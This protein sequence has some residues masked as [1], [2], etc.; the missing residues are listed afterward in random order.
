ML[1]LPRS[2]YDW[3]LRHL[4]T[5]GDTDLFPAQFEIAAIK[6]M[7]ASLRAQ[8]ADMDLSSY[9]WR[10][11]R[12]FVV[13]KSIL[14]FRIAT[15]LDPLDSLMFA[16]LIWKFGPAL[17]ASRVPVAENRVFSFRLAP[18]ENG[19]LYAGTPTW[20]DFWKTSL[21]KAESRST[22]YVIIADI[23]DFYNQVYHHVLERQLTAA[24]LPHDVSKVIKK[25]VQTLTDK[26]SRGVPVGPHTSHILGECALDAMDRSLL[27]HG[28][29]FC[30]YVDDI[31]LFVCD[32]ESAMGA[33]YEL[34][35]ILDNQQRLM[36]QNEKTRI[37]TTAEF[38][39]LA[40]SML[41][42]R[43]SNE[44]EKEILAL[45]DRESGGDPYRYLSLEELEE[46]E[47]KLLSSD[48]LEELVSIYVESEKIEYPRLSWLLRRLTQ[49]GAP[50]AVDVILSRLDDFSPI[51][52]PVARYIMSA[53][54]NLTRSKEALGE[55]VVHA[56]AMTVIK[57][58][59]YL[60]T[61]LLDILA[62]LPELDHADAITA[63]YADSN[64]IIR[65]E[66][67]RVAGS[68]RRGAWLREHKGDFRTMDPWM[69]RAFIHAAPALPQEEARFWLE[70]VRDTMSPLEKVV[71][72]H[73][74]K[75]K[76]AKK[77]KLGEIQIAA[78]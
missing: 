54:P 35:Q 72:C 12:R 47:L 27:S 45:I 75:I 70:S 60:Q 14:S 53:V 74:L 58:N 55:K 7:W 42:D 1:K 67:I 8:F 31:H 52:G 20:R 2:A 18:S 57:K 50:G 6:F 5:E 77:L 73:A 40:E 33:L 41:T 17:E 37:M 25:F 69:R 13:P 3:A 46:S 63:R 65:R 28:Y 16:A 23:A 32:E 66:I 48:V 21:E 38:S 4:I 10:G 39:D 76:D 26:V 30:R 49:L 22:G 56:L 68:N 36:L 61:V 15:Q 43:P 44:R 9:A 29:D 64:P 24:N 78:I 11:G 51:L 59:P 34:A 71:A 19:R 62:T